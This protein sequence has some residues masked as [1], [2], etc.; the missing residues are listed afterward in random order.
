MGSIKP[1]LPR[2]MR[3]FLPLELQRRQYILNT[4]ATV[5]ERYGFQ[6]IE[7]PAMELRKVLMGKYGE[8][9]DQ[10]IFNVLNSGDY[11]ADI[12]KTMLEQQNSQQLTPQI[13]KRALRYDLTV[14]LAR[15]V[16]EHQHEITFPFKR[17]QIQPVWRADKP[18]KGRYREFYQCDADVIG[19]E[20]LLVDFELIQLFTAGF[21]QL[22]VPGTTIH[23][24]NRKILS[25]IAEQV[26]VADQFIGITIAID[27]MDKIGKKGVIKELAQLDLSDQQVEQI[28]TFINLEGNLPQQLNWL[29]KEFKD[30]ET[31][32]EGVQEIRKILH[33]L[34]QS[35]IPSSA[36]EFDIALARGL[37]Y[38]TGTIYE[39]TV[40]NVD[41]GSI[42]AGGR[43]DD[44]CSTFGLDNVSGIGISFGV[45]RIYDV[46]E[47]LDLFPEH[48][49]ATTQVLI[50]QFNEEVV[51][52]CL[53]YLDRLRSAGINAELFPEPK[54]L[55]KQFKYADK[56]GIPYVIV[57]G[58]EE[59]KNDKL[60][61]KDMKSGDQHDLSFDD[62]VNELKNA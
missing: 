40:D 42:A 19:T 60:G 2:G 52:E 3:D 43:Y 50:T 47:E 5:F 22:Q 41:I 28:V 25:G 37:D 20:S 55:G 35:D 45:D 11:L 16:A 12:D 8:E 17:Y 58:P 14:P 23:F 4:L 10:L 49:S 32:R 46:M 51:M 62:I 30:T 53:S 36:Y 44:L 7:T 61:L 31:G 13:S 15:Y 59:L 29:E 27:K 6:Q 48:Q 56:K 26:G 9:G 34:D 18:Q 54:K 1:R 57:A 24:N 38:Y 21:Q 39:V 33:Y